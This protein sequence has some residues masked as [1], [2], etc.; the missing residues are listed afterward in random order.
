M[1]G[2]AVLIILALYFLFQVFN[3]NTSA[4]VTGTVTRGE[5]GELVSVSGV[6]ESESTAVLTFPVND[7][8]SDIYVRV[9]DSVSEDD[10]LATLTQADLVA[11]RQN[12]AASLE[13]ARA[14]RDELIAGPRDEAREV[15]GTTIATKEAEL[16]RTIAEENEKV[17]NARVTLYSGGLEALP[18]RTSNS[19]IPPSISGTYTCEEPGTY[20]LDL[21]SSG[22][23]SG[24]SY[25]LSGLESGT[26][27]AYDQS[28]APMGNC[29]LKIQFD[30]DTAYGSSD[31]TVEVPNPR[32]ST[33]PT[34]KSAY[35]LALVTRTNNVAAAE[36]AL[37]IAQK[38]AVLENASPRS[39]ALRRAD[40]EIEQAAA[41][42]ASVNARI[43]ERTLRAP[44]DGV[45][46]DVD[47][48]RG[49]T[50]SAD[51][52]ITLVGEN[53][54]DL[55]A[56]IPE[57]DIAKLEVGQHA[58]VAFDARA[59]ETVPAVI[60]F[61]SPLAAEID[62]VAYFEAKLT[63][64][65]PPSWLR[66]GLNADIDIVVDERK[67]VLRLPNRFIITEEENVFVLLKNG[68]NLS[69]TPIRIG[70][71]GNEGFTEVIGLTEGDTVVAP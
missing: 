60:S 1:L 50:A 27:A 6:V 63:L 61:I 25:R 14:D 43:A 21:Y 39:E 46:I 12:A 62:G 53:T 20:Y 45:I 67:D 22:S 56:R 55:A 70:F 34:N 13:I 19:D 11:E 58:N 5:I 15:T 71:T 7:V 17:M 29:G 24:V 57:I 8:V 68:E 59:G 51:T 4:Q 2:A 33:Y 41:G 16:A 37:E 9:G 32:V 31:W 42:L 36:E 66:E 49:E 10:V 30:A 64:T 40:A 54:F 52:V 38:A 28:P 35:E 69:K 47:M 48:V 26:F 44:F 23:V 18:E 65:E 3:T